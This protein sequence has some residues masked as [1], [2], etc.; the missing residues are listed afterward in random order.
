MALLE[1]PNQLD[2]TV[3]PVLT[4]L[5]IAT[6][7]DGARPLIR[8]FLP[9]E[10]PRDSTD[11]RPDLKG[12]FSED[13]SSFSNPL[14]RPLLDLL[15]VLIQDEMAFQKCLSLGSERL[16]GKLRIVCRKSQVT[17]GVDDLRPFARC[18]VPKF[19]KPFLSGSLG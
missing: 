18:A 16:I 7:L 11:V 6:E 5:L 15:E 13:C 17:Q 3:A 1:R 19:A 14:V 8:L 4:R 12:A 2:E 10:R 9:F